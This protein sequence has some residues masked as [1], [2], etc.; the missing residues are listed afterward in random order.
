MRRIIAGLLWASIYNLC[1][2]P[3]AA[4]GLMHPMYAALAMSLSSVSV[5]VNALWLKWT[6]RDNC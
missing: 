5:V 6:W 1:L 2:I 4:T 3:F